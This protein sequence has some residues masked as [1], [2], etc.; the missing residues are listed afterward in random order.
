MEFYNVLHQNPI[1]FVVV[2]C[3]ILMDLAD[4]PTVVFVGVPAPKKLKILKNTGPKRMSSAVAV[5][6]GMPIR[7]PKG[8]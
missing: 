1:V 4:H 7:F 6:S 3:M 2:S 5:F 8:P